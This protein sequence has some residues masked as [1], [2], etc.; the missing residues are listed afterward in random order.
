[1]RKTNYPR[2][3]LSLFNQLQPESHD[4]LWP[5]RNQKLE[6]SLRTKQQQQ[7]RQEK[8]MVDNQSV[9]IL[10]SRRV[11]MQQL[12]PSCNQNGR[13]E[14]ADPITD[15]LATTPFLVVTSKVVSSI[16]WLGHNVWITT[17]TFLCC[18]CEGGGWNAHS[19]C[20]V[21][22]SF[23]SSSSC[24]MLPS[25]SDGAGTGVSRSKGVAWGFLAC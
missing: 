1:M 10:V 12:Q 11:F 4:S 20:V 17:I 14:F 21:F 22:H 7:N 2:L 5:V 9:T 13:L 15:H 19:W 3:K 8:Q 18:G 23:S 16:L 25:S 24:T 6:T